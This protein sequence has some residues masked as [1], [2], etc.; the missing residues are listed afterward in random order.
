MKL[1]TIACS[2]NYSVSSEIRN[3]IDGKTWRNCNIYY[4]N[5]EDYTVYSKYTRYNCIVRHTV[6]IA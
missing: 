4:T 6:G 3:A 2:G 5:P 1:A